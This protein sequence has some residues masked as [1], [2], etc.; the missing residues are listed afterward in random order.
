MSSKKA[1]E[2]EKNLHQQFDTYLVTV[3][4][5][6]KIWSILVAFLENMNFTKVRSI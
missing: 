2:I 6:V 5:T 3:K 1:T 4:S